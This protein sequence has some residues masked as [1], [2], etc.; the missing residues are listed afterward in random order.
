MA[1]RIRVQTFVAVIT[2]VCAA[3]PAGADITAL[4][5][6]GV[7]LD[8]RNELVGVAVAADGGRYVSDRGAG[9]VYRVTPNGGVTS[10]ASSL[11]RPAGLAFDS[12]GRL[13]I[14][15]EHAGRVLRLEPNG[16]LTVLA[17]GIK[18]PRWIAV[19]GDGSLY[20]S[21][22]RLT[23]PDGPDPSEGRTI[24]RL[25][26]DGTLAEVA[27]GIRAVEG[28]VRIE[29]SLVA[30]SKGLQSGASSQGVLLRYPVNPGETSERRP[31]GS[32]QV[33]SNQSDS[34]SM[35]WERFTSRRRN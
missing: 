31:R 8:N 16:S 5:P 24:V 30:A 17:T 27:T 2:L 3:V 20:I 21:A 7:V 32:A 25:G 15:E 23:S 14:A 4:A 28:L 13:L 10:A 26:A 22:H 11:D 6:F 12:A 35:R 34:H 33:S 9:I 29:G 19:S 18:T 1:W